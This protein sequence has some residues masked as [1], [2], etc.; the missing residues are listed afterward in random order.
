MC[1]H[2]RRCVFD[3][4]PFVFDLCSKEEEENR[5]QELATAA[6]DIV[7]FMMPEEEQ[8]EKGKKQGE[9]DDDNTSSS[10]DDVFEW[11]EDDD[12]GM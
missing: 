10:D 3:L 7:D 11:I 4:C 1:S 5:I 8:I 6:Q 12:S 2:C 9:K